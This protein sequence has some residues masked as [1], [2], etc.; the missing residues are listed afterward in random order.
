MEGWHRD[1]NDCRDMRSKRN[2]EMRFARSKEGKKR[3]VKEAGGKKERKVCSVVDTAVC[4]LSSRDCDLCESHG[5]DRR[6]DGGKAQ[7]V[8]HETFKPILM[9][10]LPLHVSVLH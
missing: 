2:E 7:A 6:E 8:F 4:V 3:G 5:E 10:N 1:I 9:R